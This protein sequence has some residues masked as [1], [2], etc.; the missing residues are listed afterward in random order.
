MVKFS[1]LKIIE[2]KGFLAVKNRDNLQYGA[3]L[4]TYDWGLY[5]VGVNNEIIRPE[6]V[7]IDWSFK[8]YFFFRVYIGCLLYTSDAADE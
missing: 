7:Y 6:E 5:N 1:L 4:I 8:Y 2:L 3:V